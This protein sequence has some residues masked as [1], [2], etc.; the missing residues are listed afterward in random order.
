MWILSPFECRVVF[1]P[2]CWIVSYVHIHI[3]VTV[4]ISLHQ[5]KSLCLLCSCN[6]NLD[7]NL[8][9]DNQAKCNSSSLYYCFFF[10]LVRSAD[11]FPRRLRVP[12]NFVLWMLRQC[13]ASDYHVE[14][15]GSVSVEADSTLVLRMLHM[16]GYRRRRTMLRHHHFSFHDIHHGMEVSGSGGWRGVEPICR[17]CIT[18]TFQVRKKI[19]Q[20]NVGKY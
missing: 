2:H 10:L 6:F 13:S 17:V 9:K 1:Q 19:R 7:H 11:V 4:P 3:C 15:P 20:T 14:D 12:G 18:F 16:P 5:T 8:S